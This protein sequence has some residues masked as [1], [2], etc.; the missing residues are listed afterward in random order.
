MSLKKFI[1]ETK[2]GKMIWPQLQNIK[3]RYRRIQFQNYVKKKSR[4]GKRHIFYCGICE[5]QNMGDI[6]QTYCTLKWF[7]TNYP[8]YEVIPCHTSVFMDPKCNLVSIIAKNLA[9]DDLFFFQSGYNTHDLGGY[10]DYMHQMVINAFPNNKQIMLPQTV[11]F[12]SS[13]RR[14]K[15]SEVYNSHKSLLFLARD[16]ISEEY[17]K[18]LFPDLRVLLFPDIVTTLIGTTPEKLDRNGIFLCRRKDVEQFYSESDYVEFASLLAEYD[19]VVVEDTIISVSNEDIYKD[20]GKYV[21]I[22]IEK[23]C[24]YKL[25]VTDKFHG[26]IFSLVANTPVIVLKTKDHKVTEG[27]RWFSKIYPD[28]VF[29]ADNSNEIKQVVEEIL[30]DPKY[31]ILDNYFEREYYSRLKGTIQEWEE[32]GC[33]K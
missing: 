26:L 18:Q 33:H 32:Q 2:F 3:A 14:N 13:A 22:M 5:S 8:E 29:Y 23:F 28:R 31:T 9:R 10:E 30:A 24:R 12:Q 17:A 1:R 16:P 15:C 25:V 27:Y 7:Q 11:F 20:T 4:D 19:N 6:A 21:S